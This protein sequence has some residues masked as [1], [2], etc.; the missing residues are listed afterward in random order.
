MLEVLESCIGEGE[1][2][3]FEPITSEEFLMERLREIGLKK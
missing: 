1:E 2:A 3:Q